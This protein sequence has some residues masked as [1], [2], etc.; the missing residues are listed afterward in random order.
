MNICDPLLQN[1]VNFASTIALID[2]DH[3]ITYEELERRVRHTASRLIAIGISPGKRVGI[4]LRDHADHVIAMLAVGRIGAVVLPLDWRARPQEKIGLANQFEAALIL[5]D[6]DAKPLEHARAMAFSDLAGKAPVQ[7]PARHF[8]RDPGLPFL[9]NFSSG[10][11][12]S[13]KPVYL[14]HGQIFARY[15]AWWTEL[16]L[17]RGHRYLSALPLAYSFGRNYLLYNLVAGNTVVLHPPLFRDRELITAMRENKITMGMF[18]ATILR[19]LLCLADGDG[20]LLPGLEILISGAAPLHPEEKRSIVARVNPNLV[21]IYGHN[22]AGVVSVLRPDEIG[23]HAESVGKQCFL[24]EVEIV[25]DQ[26]HRANPGDT[27]W[28][29]CRGPQVASGST[30]ADGNADPDHATHDGWCYT[31]EL[32]AM[33]EAGYIYLKDRADDLINSGGFS[34]YPLEIERVLT[35]HPAVAEAAVVGVPSSHDGE[36]IVAFVVARKPI[37]DRALVAH[38]RRQLTGHKV[39]REFVFL[40]SLPKSAAGKV[41]KRNLAAGL[42]GQTAPAL[43]E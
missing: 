38:C 24:S 27:G 13:P 2:G 15:V 14:T 12:G 26:G 9:I 18:P 16:G 33:D 41:L 37:E 23:A 7:D 42:P 36:A 43:A 20:L 6:E 35:A 30:E 1:A 34:I 22:G 29:R 5:S 4:A 10:S 17:R 28:L 8:V 25:D 11:T 31:G 40:D 32:A 3:E 21:E 39:P 19:R